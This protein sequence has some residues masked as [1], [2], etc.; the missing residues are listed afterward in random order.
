MCIP[1][2]YTT[3]SMNDS[4][5][6]TLARVARGDYSSREVNGGGGGVNRARAGDS[7]RIFTIE[8][9]CRVYERAIRVVESIMN[10]NRFLSLE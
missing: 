4:V 5:N 3:Q 8:R 9:C 10:A 7:L 1:P 2:P 6:S